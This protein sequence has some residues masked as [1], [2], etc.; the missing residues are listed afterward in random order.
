MAVR[1]IDLIQTPHLRLNLIAGHAAAETAKVLWAQTSDLEAPWEFMTAGE[2]LMKNGRT[3]PSSADDQVE[4]LRSLA[5]VQISGLLIGMD[6]MTPEICPETI[7]AANEVGLPI[8]TAPFSVSFASIAKAVAYANDTDERRR[9]TTTQ[10]LY[11]VIRRAVAEPSTD[12]LGQLGKELT[13]KLAVIDA[14]TG[15]AALDGTSAPPASLVTQ[16]LSEVRERHGVVPGVIHLSSDG[17]RGA[18]VEVP[19]EEPT[20]LLA[21]GF[22]DSGPDTVLLQHIATAAAVF[23]AQQGMRREHE[24]RLGAELLTHLMDGR[25][26][27]EFS[28]TRLKRHG[29]HVSSTRVVAVI[30]G[31]DTGQQQLHVSLARRGISHLLVRRSE[32]LYAL[33]TP[34]ELALEVIRR[35]LGD[36]ALIGLSDTVGAVERIPIAAQE[37]VW[38]ARAAISTPN[39][40]SHYRDATLLSVLRDTAEARVVVDRVLGDLIR[41]DTEHQA[42]LMKTLDTYLRCRRSWQATATELN[43]HRQTVIYRVRRIEEITGRTLSESAHIAELWLALRARELTAVQDLNPAR[44]QFPSAAATKWQ[45]RVSG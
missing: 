44:R 31:N 6:P 8:I 3:L 4:F 17:V 19:D 38:A 36:D 43:V 20:L 45:D 9:L 26:D 30:G 24:R 35:R 21:Y 7:A 18:A 29:I 41:Y 42:E 11:N 23:L 33:L 16:A 39:R 27:Q 12:L 15:D 1:M 5:G 22:R 34:N 14:L 32:V 25:L 28:H 10:R 37:A 2:L 13:C 40:F